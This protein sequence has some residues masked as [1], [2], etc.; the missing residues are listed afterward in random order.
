MEREP[1]FVTREWPKKMVGSDSVES[2]PKRLRSPPLMI[3]PYSLCNYR[4]WICSFDFFQASLVF[5]IF[6][7]F[8]FF[9][10]WF[11]KDT[12]TDITQDL[13]KKKQ[14]WTI[15]SL[16]LFNGLTEHEATF[17]SFSDR[18]INI[19]ILSAINKRDARWG[20]RVG[21]RQPVVCHSIL[22]QWREEEEKEEEKKKTTRGSQKRRNDRKTNI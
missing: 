2:W 8:F 3:T 12:H 20:S 14:S 9:G 13:K 16:S 15:F 6:P 7:F 5:S 21:D 10:G 1:S 17:F 4:E 18:L 19:R 22:Y 11:K